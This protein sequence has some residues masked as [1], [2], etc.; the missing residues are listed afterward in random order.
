LPS[1]DPAPESV[2]CAGTP[3]W[4]AWEVVVLVLLVLAGYALR[5]GALPLRGEE[6]TRAQGALEMVESG[7]WIVPR[8]QGE[9]YRIRAPMQYWMIAVSCLALGTWN[10]WA[11]RFPSVVA[12]LCTVLLIYGYARLSLSRFGAF[13]AAAA[14]A[15]MADIFKMGLY[16]ETEAVFIF[17]VTASLFVWHWGMLRRWPDSVTYAAG[18]GFMAVGML[19]KSFQAPAYFGAGIG[20]YLVLSGQW[21]RLFCRGHLAGMLVGAAVLLAWILPY[22]SAMG[23]DAVCMVWMGDPVVAQSGRIQN[24]DLAEFGA[25]FVTYPLEIAAGTLPWCLLL[26]LYL[27]RDFRMAIG[28]ARPQVFFLVVCMGIALPTCWLPPTGAPRYFATFF[29]ALAVL[30]GLA[31]QRCAEADTPLALRAAWRRYLLLLAPIVVGAPLAVVAL[32]TFGAPHPVLEPWV[33][34]PRAATAYALTFAALAVALLRVRAAATPLQVRLSVF[35]LVAFLLILFNGVVTDVR[36]YRSVPVAESVRQLKEQLPPG[37]ALVSI[38]G[39]VDCLFPYYYGPPLIAPRPWPA[40]GSEPDPSLTYF[41]FNCPGDTRPALPFAW[42][43]IAAINMDRNRQ[44]RPERVVVVGMRL[45]TATGSPLN[46][47]PVSGVGR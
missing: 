36:V 1:T 37:Q 10:E 9:P 11:V 39:H 31:I 34:P 15:T 27:R 45:T 30:I 17:E 4:R 20:A 5:A 47:L 24:W 12:T 38:G 28:A 33:E 22:A 21:R 46:A 7:N 42:R 14:F 2:T 6:P 43:E 23:W 32:A 25:H 16:A 8:E 41:C 29:P 35:V 3:W 13:A 19:T 44:D 26:A 18:Y 40:P